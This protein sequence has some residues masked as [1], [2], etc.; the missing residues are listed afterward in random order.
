LNAFKVELFNTFFP[1]FM[2]TCIWKHSS[3]KADKTMPGKK[4]IEK[5]YLSKN[6]VKNKCSV[7]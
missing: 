1:Q 7:D 3:N 6:P 4:L 2:I 5:K